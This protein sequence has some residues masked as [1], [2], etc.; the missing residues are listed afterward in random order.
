MSRRQTQATRAQL[1]TMRINAKHT[2]AHRARHDQI[3]QV[4]FA[5][6]KA[7]DI[8]LDAAKVADTVAEHLAQIGREG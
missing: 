7:R 6:I 2:R 8:A 4:Q 1:R 3:E 5:A